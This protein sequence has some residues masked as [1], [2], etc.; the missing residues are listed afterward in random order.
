MGALV[1]NIF[2]WLFSWIDRIIILTLNAVYGLLM[3]LATLN[4]VNMETVKTFSNRI[5]LILGIFMLFNIA[6]NLL[7]Y[8]VSPDKFSDS[9]QGGTKIIANIFVSLILLGTSNI[10]FEHA[11]KLQYTVLKKQIIPQI[12]FGTSSQDPTEDVEISYYIF[13]G[14]IS[15]NPDIDKNGVCENVYLS[16]EIDS[17]CHDLLN[18]MLD[19]GYYQFQRAVEYK[20]ASKLLTADNIT[21]KGTT[22][23]GNDFV[24]N[25]YFIFSTIIGIITTLIMFNF[26]LD[27]AK[28]TVKL[29]FYQL[30]AP[31]PI[32]ANMIPGKGSETFKKWYKSCIAT[33]LDI[34]IRLVALFFAIFVITTIYSSLPDLFSSHP[35]LG[36]FIILGALMFA[37]ELPKLLQDIIGIKMDDK[38]TINPLKKLSQSPLAAG[39]IGYAGGRIGGAVS[40]VWGASVQNRNVRKQLDAEGLTKGTSL[41]NERFKELH[42][43]TLAGY[44]G[45]AIAGSYSAGIRSFWVGAT[46]G[47]NKS[48]GQI[49]S[50]GI[51][52]AGLARNRRD[53]G[54]NI[55]SKVLDTATNIA[56]IKN[57]YGTTDK[58]KGEVKKYRQDLE[59]AKQ[60]ENVLSQSL[61]RQMGNYNQAMAALSK[62]FD[63]SAIRERDTNKFI[64]YKVKTYNDFLDE[65]AKIE[66]VNDRIA[67][68]ANWNNYSDEERVTI[69]QQYMDSWSSLSETD[70]TTRRNNVQ[71]SGILTEDQFNELNNIYNS[72]NEYDVQARD[73][74]KKMKSAEENM[75]KQNGQK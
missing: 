10:I 32:I 20:D 23:S 63:N 40:N 11:Y 56:Q 45:S 66:F 60:Q 58:L 55:G 57:D 31:I 48:L 2:R 61:T 6:I 29:Y 12:I 9:K 42:G 38:F 34:F 35:I 21:A 46:G 53:A 27:I 71:A 30:I 67:G 59:N 19:K 65:Q 3:K 72:K 74:E 52:G 5:G 15:I 43:N 4:I 25:Y 33:Y 49:M 64:A 8:I 28:R 68:D 62:V 51:S 7:T 47:G 41:Y 69:K 17:E 13:S 75:A 70:K 16:G 1:E 18:P 39:V 22:D 73:L 36:I 54:Y 44:F 26:C 37:K 14:L 50:G 24:F